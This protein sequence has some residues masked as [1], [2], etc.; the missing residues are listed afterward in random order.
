VILNNL[1]R[2]KAAIT[3]SGELREILVTGGQSNSGVVVNNET[4][5]RDTAVYSCVSVIAET[6]GQLPYILYQRDGDKKNRAISSNL[7]SL[8]HDAPNSF[9][10]SFDWR[11]TKTMHVA[12]R[13][14]GYSFINK[15]VT[16]EVLEFLP[17]HPDN[18]EC[19]QNSDYTLSYVFTDVEGNRIPLRQDQVFRVMGKSLDGVT[20]MSAISYHRETI[21]ISMAADKHSALSLK[22]GA[23]HSGILKHPQKLKDK[24]VANRIRESWDESTSGDNVG[25]TA[26]LEEGMEWQSI[27]MTNKDA[28]YIETRKFRVEDIARIFRMPPHKIGHLERSTNNNIEHQA[29]E[30]VTD[31]MM[32]WFKRWEQSF[33]LYVLTKQQRK[34]YFSELL[35]DGLLRGDSESRSNLYAMYIQNGVMSPN[36]VRAKEN[37]NPRQGGDEYYTPLNMTTGDSDEI[38]E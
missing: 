27:S 10:T 7:Y 1:F 19:H 21:G 13:G 38:Q 8:I 17:M 20:P 24:D 34:E 23:K 28:Q 9:Q 22:N 36:E 32:P 16:G 11:V 33:A 26:L 25:K 14:V 3:D 15:S 12:L 18:V 29:L 37:L 31:T 5:L 4:A 30:F 35:V 2:P 6:V